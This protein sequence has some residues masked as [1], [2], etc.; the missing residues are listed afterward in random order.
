L[1]IDTRIPPREYR[2]VPFAAH[3]RTLIWL[4]IVLSIAAIVRLRELTAHAYMLD[5]CWSVEIATGRGSLHQ[6]LPLNQI[7]SPPPQFYSLADAPPWWRIWSNMEVTHPPVYSILLRWWEDLFGDTDY[8]GRLF[9]VLASLIAI[10]I[11][12]DTVRLQAGL[13]PAIWA[14]LLMALATPQ[15]EHARLTRSYTVLTAIALLAANLVIRIQRTGCSRGKLVGLTAAVLATLL[16][17]Y[18]SVGAMAGLLIYAMW[19]LP[20]HRRK[21]FVAFAS[22]AIIFALSWG[23]WMWRQRH[24]FATD[25]PSTLFLTSDP[26]HHIRDTLI[27]VLMDPIRLLFPATETGITGILAML[28]GV[29]GVAAPLVPVIHRR[30]S[31]LM[32]WSLWIIGTISV[33][34]ALDLTRGTDHLLYIRYTI[35][36]SPA[37]CAVLP[38]LFA[39]A[40]RWRSLLHLT[41]GLAVI[42]CVMNLPDVYNH[43]DV[44]PRRITDDFKQFN[45]VPNSN[46]LLV[47]AAAPEDVPKLQIELFMLTRYLRPLGCPLVILT[48]PPDAQLAKQ[49]SRCSLVLLDMQPGDWQTYFP[50]RHLLRGRTYRNLGNVFTLEN[51]QTDQK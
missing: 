32:L 28:A 13:A 48:H 37:V 16:T 11:L 12:F 18:F 7:I 33:V 30:N 4:A 26:S 5:E 41:A 22:S 2:A 38:S 19:R 6:H 47:F 44:D 45:T 14:G 36:A 17:H 25:D 8:G 9:S 31:T 27:R 51:A 15:V 43:D 39:S 24:L 34:A 35:L 21:I 10:A 29:G 49:M 20:N 46:D 23:P 1:T 40:G 50:D 42:G 3:R